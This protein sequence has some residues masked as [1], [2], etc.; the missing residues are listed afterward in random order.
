MSVVYT[1]HSNL[2][3]EE[4]MKSGSVSF[5]TSAHRRLKLTEKDKALVKALEKTRVHTHSMRML[6]IPRPVLTDCL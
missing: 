4:S 6:V 2:R 1:P 5:H 3:K